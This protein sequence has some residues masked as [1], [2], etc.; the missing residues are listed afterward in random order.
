MTTEILYQTNIVRESG[1]LYF[2]NSEGDLCRRRIAIKGERP[3]EEVLLE[4]K[5]KFMKGWLYYLDK[6]SNVVKTKMAKSKR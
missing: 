4:F 5:I 1:F 2:L 3:Q 6:D